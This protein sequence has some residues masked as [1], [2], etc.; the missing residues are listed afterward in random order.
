MQPVSPELRA[1]VD[2]L[3]TRGKTYDQIAK[4]IGRTKNA[5]AGIVYRNRNPRPKRVPFRPDL[6]IS[7]VSDLPP[8]E[9]RYILAVTLNLG[10]SETAR[11]VGRTPPTIAHSCHL[12]EDKRDDYAYDQYLEAVEADKIR[13]AGP[14]TGPT[15]K[16]QN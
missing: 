12:I 6:D 4:A 5:V 11:R 10:I 9:A 2:R 7:L 8:H 13:Q 14:E 15:G 3:L 1:R 16:V